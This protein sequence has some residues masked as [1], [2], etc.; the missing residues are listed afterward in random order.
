MQDGIR[1]VTCDKCGK[2]WNAL[3]YA[4]SERL[5]CPACH[6]MVEVP[7]LEGMVAISTATNSAIRQLLRRI[8]DRFLFELEVADTGQYELCDLIDAVVAQLPE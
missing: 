6:A 5:E 2:E 4:D 8:K 3:C 7:P 1:F